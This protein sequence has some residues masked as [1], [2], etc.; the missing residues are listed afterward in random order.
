MSL[1]WAAATP[2]HPAP[3]L[4]ESSAPDT[5][6]TSGAVSAAAEAASTAAAPRSNAAGVAA[7]A[8]EAAAAEGLREGLL[9][10]PPLPRAPW[11][12]TTVAAALA[13]NATAM[14]ALP[15]GHVCVALGALQ[16]FHRREFMTDIFVSHGLLAGRPCL[17]LYMV[18]SQ[19]IVQERFATRYRCHGNA[20]V[21]LQAPARHDGK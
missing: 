5:A 9:R 18:N 16:L 19:N 1:V 13:G 3:L 6:S 2:A 15:G 10:A 11:P 20:A 4:P 8:A 21:H 17:E 12:G 7:Q 14:C